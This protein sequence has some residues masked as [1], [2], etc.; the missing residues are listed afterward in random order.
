MSSRQISI[1]ARDLLGLSDILE[2]ASMV[3]K[4]TL[5]QRFPNEG[6]GPSNQSLPTMRQPGDGVTWTRKGTLGSISDAGDPPGP[7][8]QALL[9]A[10]PRLSCPLCTS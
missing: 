4:D 2:E 5:F 7:I 3:C 6:R 9:I 10:R 8:I 1:F